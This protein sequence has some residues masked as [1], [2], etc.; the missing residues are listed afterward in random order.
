MKLLD[1]FQYIFIFLSCVIF[2]NTC[3]YVTCLDA[4][5]RIKEF[6][7][8]LETYEVWTDDRAHLG[9]ERIPHNGNKVIGRPVLLMHGMFS[10]SV[11]F[12]AQNSSLSFVLSDAGFDVWLYNS[13]GTGL[14]RTLSIYKGPGSLPNMNRVSWDFSFHELGVYDLT[15]VI[16]FILK[17][18]EYSKLDIVGY[19][20]GAT[21]AFVCLSDKPEYNDKINKLALIAPATNFKTS[22][23]TA[24]VKQF[25]DIVLI[26]LNGFDFFPFTVDPDTTLSKLRNMCEN[27]SVLMSCKRFIDVLDGVDLPIDKSSVL[28]F[29]A[30]F[31]QPVSSKLLK[32]YLQVVMK[33]K[34]S[35]YDYGTSGNLLRYNKIMPPDYDLSKVTVPIFVINSKADYLSTPKDIK[36]LTNVLPNIKEIRY[37]DQVKGGHLSFV[38]NPDT[39]EIV[40]SFIATKLLD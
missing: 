18:S 19:S 6:G 13:R 20:L 15:A 17:K 25:S 40:N 34:L 8:P 38:I 1:K 16:D 22:P 24:I 21:V 29:A 37:I 4:S 35:H 39:R 33:D 26:I 9:L 30:A 3:D 14:S 12:A 10:D 7:Y 31:P 27:E 11:V 5:Q 36:R 23:V 32:H 2:F 28:D